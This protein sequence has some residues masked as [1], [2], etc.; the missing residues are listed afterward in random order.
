MRTQNKQ[1]P[2]WLPHWQASVSTSKRASTH[3]SIAHERAGRGRP[4]SLPHIGVGT[5]PRGANTNL[6]QNACLAPLECSLTALYVGVSEE[7]LVEIGHGQRQPVEP[8]K[9]AILMHDQTTTTKKCARAEEYAR[10]DN[11]SRPELMPY[12]GRRWKTG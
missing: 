11:D 3:R 6:F 5:G 8:S 1:K 9:H 4:S 12:M 10:R 2:R 7:V